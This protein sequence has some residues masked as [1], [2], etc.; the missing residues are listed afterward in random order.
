MKFKN[1]LII[2]GSIVVAL[3][4][5]IGLGRY[6]LPSH[7]GNTTLHESHPAQLGNE[8]MK[9]KIWTCSMH[10]QIRQPEAGN[11]P[12]C[13][14][15][16]IPLDNDVSSDD[17]PRTLVMSEAGKALAE[18][19]T[20]PV[21][22][23]FLD[24]EIRL[25][26]QLEY[27]ETKV[28]SIT[29][30]FPA[31]IDDLFVNFIGVPVKK[32]EHLG[33]V[34]SPDLL[35]AQKELLTA[36]KYD[37]NSSTTQ[38]ARR[39]LSLWD[40]LPEQIDQIIENGAAKDHF[41]LRSPIGGIVVSKN[42]KEGDYVKTGESLFKI[43]D[44]SRLWLYLDAYE[45][46]LTWLRY[47]QKVTFSVEAYP[48]KSFEGL[49]AFINPEFN[50]KNRTVSVRVNVPNE[51]GLLKPGMFARGLVQSR[52]AAGSR[53]F[54]PQFAGKWISPMHP[55]IVKDSPGKCDVCNMDLVSAEELGYVDGIEKN[56]PLVIPASSVLRTGKRAVVYVEIPNKERPT[57]EG[58]EIKLGSRAGDFYIIEEG[59]IESERVVTKG[60]FKIDSALQIQAKPSMMNPKGGGPAP[61]HKHGSMSGMKK[62]KINGVEET[63][64]RRHGDEQ[65]SEIRITPVLAKELMP[66]YL[67]LQ[68]ALASDDIE[69]ARTSLKAMIEVTGHSG[70]VS[71]LIHSMLA[72]ESLESIRLPY[73]E[74]FS[75]AMIETVR[76]NPSYFDEK[77]LLMYCPMANDN[78][79]ANWL[80]SKEPLQNP[81]FGAVMLKC[82]EI[83]SKLVSK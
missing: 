35:T 59:L 75:E 31:R 77:L 5:G 34:Y 63:E 33:K 37:P 29:A 40:L 51:N 6:V 74:A 53:V 3:I 69:A 43:V 32:G 56:S 26:G 4:L 14:M 54:A 83:K 1:I 65:I 67:L 11:C 10:P 17:G 21:E 58:R 27:D 55:E 62:M 8:S 79:G 76:V 28:K 48:G 72:G 50:R 78:Q 57:Y 18:I 64:N 36:I 46:D 15:D 47:G 39:K 52:M 22:R 23:R 25:V 80:Q 44:L 24:A 73:F 30:R 60:A 41:I 81:Y 19:Q 66:G 2:C 7:A 49:I 71:K 82:G 38:S 68:N 16:L 9:A 61:G 70:S 12:I 42:V 13:G 45:S 20:S